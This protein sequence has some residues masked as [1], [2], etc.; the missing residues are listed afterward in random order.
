MRHT[1]TKV[2]LRQRL[3]DSGRISLYLDY[4][5]AIRNPETMQMTR[6]EYLGIYLYAHPKNEM[7][8]SFNN[9]M[10]NKAEAIRCIRVQSLINEE[11]GF[12]DRTKMKTDFLAYFLKM[13]RKK[14]QKW[15]IVY[16]HFYNYVQGHCTFGDVTI[17][18]CQGFREYLLNAK[19]LKQKGNVSVNSASGYFSTFRGL[20]KIAY[21]DKWLRENINDFLDKIEAKEVK[22]EYLTLDEVKI[23]AQMPCEHDVLK[24]ASL[25]SCL[26]GLRISDILN[27]RWEDFT[28]APDQGYCIRIRTQ[29]TSTEATLPISYEA[30]ELCGEP[31]LGKV[32]RGLQRSMINYPLKKWIK[33]AGITKHITFHCFRHSYAV[34][35][36]SLGTDIYTVSKML[37]HKNVSTTQIYADLVNSKK[38]ET[39]EKIS[40]K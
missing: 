29:K 2:T 20:L 6:R 19:Q 7:E 24:R 9:D 13:C 15:R 14:D 33:Q 1:C 3:Y 17:E 22:K 10:L 38:R 21:R 11:F 27:L 30:Y 23:L 35:Q 16:Q 18:L 26:T 37:T 32:F 12:L 8:R 25:F 31:S 39:A 36:I 34:I 40:L 28:L 4:Y 5:P